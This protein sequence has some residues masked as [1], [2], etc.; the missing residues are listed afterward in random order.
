MGAGIGIIKHL[1]L[2]VVVGMLLAGSLT[3][4]HSLIHLIAGIDDSLH[5]FL[6]QV[7]LGQLLDFQ[8]CLQLTT[9]EDRL[10][11]LSDGIQEYL[12]RI[13]NQASVIGPAGTTGERDTGEEGRAGGLH[14]IESLFHDMVSHAYVWTVFQ[15]TGRDS[16]L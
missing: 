14:I 11:K 12:A 10:G 16:V 13:D 8:V 3:V 6:L 9:C 1:H 7:F 5:I 4:S 2:T 15:Q